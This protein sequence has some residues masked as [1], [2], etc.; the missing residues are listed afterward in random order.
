M[1]EVK[2]RLNVANPFDN[3][4]NLCHKMSQNAWDK[5]NLVLRILQ[6]KKRYV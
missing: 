2:V 3:H 5:H 4:F 1:G 6:D